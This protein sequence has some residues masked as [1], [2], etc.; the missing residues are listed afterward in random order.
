[1]PSLILLCVVAF[2]VTDVSAEPPTGG[3]AAG[4]R[5]DDAT[6]RSPGETATAQPALVCCYSR[7]FRKYEWRTGSCRSWDREEWFKVHSRRCEEGATTA[8]SPDASPAEVRRICCRYSTTVVNQPIF[9]WDTRET[10][11]LNKGTPMRSN[12]CFAVTR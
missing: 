3:R 5:G 2:A 1:M 4:N 6:T 7:R 9:K 8:R 12:E 10:C 11:H